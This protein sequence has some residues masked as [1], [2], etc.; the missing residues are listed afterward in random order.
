MQRIHKKQA[1]RAWRRQ[2][3]EKWTQVISGIGNDQ[4]VMSDL[5]LSTLRSLNERPAPRRKRLRG[6][7]ERLM[8]L[9]TR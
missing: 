7:V 5:M 6:L 4:E 8:E 9:S 2:I 3:F 1:P